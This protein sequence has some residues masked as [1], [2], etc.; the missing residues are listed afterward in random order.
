MSV[1]CSKVKISRLHQMIAN[2]AHYLGVVSVAKLRHQYSD[3]PRTTIPKRARQEARLIIEFL[4]CGLNAV[5]CGL[6]N[7]TPR[8][9]I[10]YKGNFRGIQYE[11][12]CK[13]FQADGYILGWFLFF[14]VLFSCRHTIAARLSTIWWLCQR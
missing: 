8:N 12:F 5:P 11:M 10:Q 4:G 14:H 7:G 3:S 9:F 6:G 13:L 2:A 1:M